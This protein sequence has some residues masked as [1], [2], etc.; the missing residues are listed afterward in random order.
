MPERFR[1]RLRKVP[2]R[3]VWIL[4]LAILLVVLALFGLFPRH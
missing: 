1:Q 4:I 2:W 3:H